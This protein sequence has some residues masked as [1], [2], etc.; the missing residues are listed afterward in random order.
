MQGLSGKVNGH[1]LADITRPIKDK[2]IH[3]SETCT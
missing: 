1:V 2:H 3:Q